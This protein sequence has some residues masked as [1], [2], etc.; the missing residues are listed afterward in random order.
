MSVVNGFI[1][2]LQKGTLTRFMV[3]IIDITKYPLTLILTIKQATLLNMKTYGNYNMEYGLKDIYS[4]DAILLVEVS[5][6]QLTENLDL[7]EPRHTHNR[8]RTIFSLN[9]FQ[10]KNAYSKYIEERLLFVLFFLLSRTE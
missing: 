3:F 7:I 1:H 10:K 2:Q 6:E 8:P 9:L 4:G 5:R